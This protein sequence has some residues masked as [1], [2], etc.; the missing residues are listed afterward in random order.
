MR[1]TGV[2]V[3]KSIRGDPMQATG[4]RLFCF[5]GVVI[6]ICICPV[7]FLAEDAASGDSRW[8][9]LERCLNEGTNDKFHRAG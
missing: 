9:G 8:R 6:R 2:R 4:R 3:I 1:L 7:P 5:A